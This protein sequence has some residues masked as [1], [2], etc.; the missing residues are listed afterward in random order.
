MTDR[1]AR[2]GTR[3]LAPRTRH[4]AL[5]RLSL[6]L[7][8]LFAHAAAA[9]ARDFLWKATSKTG[10]R[11]Y[12]VGSVH[13]LTQDFYPLSLS[14]DQAFKESDLLVEEVDLAEMLS[15]AAQTLMLGRGMLPANTSLDA[16]VA[17]ATLALVAQRTK[18]LGL[19]I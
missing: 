12:L 14:I 3:H 8:L 11:V 13:L 1:Y 17:P 6:C 2:S 5:L 19:P 18:E 7:T 16:V 9:S 4:L 10:G 15:P